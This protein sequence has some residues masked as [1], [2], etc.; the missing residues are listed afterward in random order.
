MTTMTESIKAEIKG[1][2]SGQVA[3]G[4]YILQIGDING[5]IVNVVP[6]T[7]QPVIE[8]RARPVNMKPRPFPSLLDRGAETATIK[9]AL[10]MSVPVSVF[11]TGGMGKTSLLRRVAHLPEANNFS[12]GIVYLSAKDQGLDDLLQLLFDA[13]HTSPPNTKPTDGQIRNGLEDIKALILLDDISLERD[14]IEALL[15]DMPASMFVFAS[16]DRSLWGEGQ[17]VSLH[18]LPDDEALMLFEKELGRSL[19]DSERASVKEVLSMLEDQ[20]LRILQIASSS[21]ESEKSLS[22]IRDQL[23]G[24]DTDAAVVQFALGNLSES[25]KKVLAVLGAAGAVVPF[26]HVANLSEVNRPKQTLDSLMVLSLVQAHSPRYSLTAVMAR[27]LPNLWNL[28]AWED[29]LIDY[30]SRWT[31][32]QPTRGLMED[33]TDVLLAVMQKANDKKRWQDVIQLGRA[34]EESLVFL[35]RWQA[36]SELLNLTLA[37]ARALGD[38]K[39]EAWA[40]HQLGSR[41]L[42]IGLNDQAQ[43]FLGRA[44]NIRQLIGDQDGL[45][46]TQHNLDTLLHPPTPQVKKNG[47][48]PRWLGKGFMGLIILA[49]TAGLVTTTVSAISGNKLAPP[50]SQIIAPFLGSKST[51]L[52][53]SPSPLLTKPF[54]S[55]DASKPTTHTLLIPDTGATNVPTGPLTITVTQTKATTYSP[56]TRTLTP[57]STPT[58]T[59]TPTSTPTSLGPKIFTPIAQILGV[60][61]DSG[62]TLSI[63][64]R[65]ISESGIS[66]YSVWSTWGGGGQIDQSFSAPLPTVIDQ[67]VVHTHAI[68]DPVDRQHQV[69]LK[70]TT[71]DNSQPIYIYALEPGGRCPGHFQ[72]PIT[73]TP[74]F[75]APPP[76]ITPPDIGSITVSDKEADYPYTCN[77]STTITVITT[78]N[79]DSSGVNY[80]TLYY[81][82]DGNKL[83][84]TMAQ[85]DKDTYQTTIDVGNEAGQY[86]GGKD[87]ILYISIEAVDKAG[88]FNSKGYGAVP[89]H[90][91]TG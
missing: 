35:K 91:C 51:L 5:G 42:C 6:P 23:Q 17:I 88:N 68:L 73:L 7:A 41:A 12:D 11:G 75:T 72:P 60:E 53:S 82:Y 90:Y 84:A 4:N 54:T 33:T 89:V 78:V 71:P 64:I 86:F 66:S 34:V 1:T 49:V 21:R 10:E 69:G 19:S 32:G 44:L 62:L 80:V 30:F 50:I 81:D 55:T 63:H 14:A 18:G 79:D 24:Q 48:P 22:E 45:A 37:A 57:S 43:D 9:S 58:P 31:D 26:Q 52:A 83:L 8:P 74:T 3:V 28:S 2:V 39:V 13:F 56:T 59:R 61:C 87:G 16:M 25:Q 40:L 46:V 85:V 65:I 76:D 70:V 47:R 20:P 67:V 27:T 36:W 15:N 77:F 38:Q 29:I